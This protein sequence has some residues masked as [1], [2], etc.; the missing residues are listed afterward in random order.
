MKLAFESLEWVKEIVF[1]RGHHT[2]N[3]RPECNK[4]AEERRICSFPGGTSGKEPPCQC[5]VRDAVSVYKSGRFPGGEHGNPLH[6]SCL[7]NP[8]DR[9]AWRAIVHRVKKSWQ[10]WSS[11]AYTL[12]DYLSCNISLSQFSDWDLQHWHSWF[13][14][15][16]TWIVICIMSSPGSQDSGFGLKL[17]HQ[18]SSVSKLQITDLLSLYN[19]MN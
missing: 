8:M 12:P 11:L 7:E 6:H 14:S 1:T 17:Y 10:D 19:H 3:W 9:G 13:P 15:L 16:Q 2:I 5:Q 18:L 4:K